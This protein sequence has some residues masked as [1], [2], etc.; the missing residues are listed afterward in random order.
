MRPSVAAGHAATAD[1]G[2]EILE[3]GGNAADAAVAASLASCVAETVM[4]GVLG[5]GHAA[6]FWDGDVQLLDFFCA[7]PGLGAGRRDVEL[8]HLQ[9][10]FGA[11][12][13]HYAVGIGSCAV[14]RAGAVT[15]LPNSRRYLKCAL[16]AL[17]YVG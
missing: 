11:E 8:E 4:T 7:V 6:V 5:G 15:G 16:S 17:K 13:V 14:P 10:P 3:E 2:A 12:L 1:A 9:V